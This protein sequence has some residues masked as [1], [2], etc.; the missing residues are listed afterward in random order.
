MMRTGFLATAGFL[1]FSGGVFAQT[2]QTGNVLYQRV[3]AMGGGFS[4]TKMI[5]PGFFSPETVAGSP[6]SAT[7][8]Q[9]SLQVLGDG[10][11]IEQ[12]ESRQ[13][14]RDSQGRTRTETGKPG[15]RIIAIQDP[16]AGTMVT[17]N[18]ASKTVEKSPAPRFLQDLQK[19]EAGLAS[20][21]VKIAT[22]VGIEGTGG[23]F[24]KV[25]VSGA[26]MPGNAA[27][28]SATKPDTEELPVQNVNGVL[29]SGKRTTL[30]IPA[31]EIGN[32]RP[33][34]VVGE[35]WFSNELQMMVKSSNSDPRFGD[36]S[37][38]LMNISRAEPDPSLFQAPADY[39]V[40]ESKE[41]FFNLQ[42]P[43]PPP[44]Q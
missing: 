15:A 34:R 38:E 18:E 25:I 14:Y 31:G 2:V 42:V 35:S 39:K 23:E 5:G 19:R 33:I 6:F 1:L 4:T 16:V 8:Q 28:I 24:G 26:P 21:R 3:G 44:N 37:F 20:A 10:T 29:A 17:L 36:T 30:T 13:V 43:P 11:R 22:R 12:T 27:V 7:D 9:H 41:Q 32:D 40:V